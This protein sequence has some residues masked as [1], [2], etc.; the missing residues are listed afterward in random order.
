MD[1]L[2]INSVNSYV[3]GLDMKGR[4]RQKKEK[5][6]FSEDYTLNERQR[7]NEMFKKSYME[8]REND[9]SDKTLSAI[10]N[11]IAVGSKLTPDEMKYLQVKNPTLYQKL[12]DIEKEKKQYEEDLKKCKTKEDVDRL[13]MSKISSSLSA[14]NSV[15]NNPNIPESKKLE[16]AAQ[17]QRRLNELGKIEAKFIKSGEYAKLP[18][19]E[20]KAKAE[21]DMREAEENLRDV[22]EDRKTE[23]KT[24]SKSETDSQYEYKKDIPENPDV[25][26]AAA[27]TEKADCEE[28]LTVTE[29]ELTPE[30][31]KVKRAR[32]KAA[33]KSPDVDSSEQQIIFN[34]KG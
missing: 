22:T 7:K 20:E 18:T 2:M 1:F 8:Q 28:K 6:D 27:D 34:A 15:K 17:E 5:A 24:V 11:K 12:K 16:I 21:K 29:A 30:A 3:K 31:K 10:N 9:D 4:W 23:E 33:Y 19:E 14:I 32:A 26:E 13:K 25:E